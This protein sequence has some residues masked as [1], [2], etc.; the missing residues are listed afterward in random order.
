MRFFPFL[1]ATLELGA[2]GVYLY[3]RHWRLA[4]IWGCYA[5]ATYALGFEK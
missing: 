1:I 3:H 4:L 5:I 2:T